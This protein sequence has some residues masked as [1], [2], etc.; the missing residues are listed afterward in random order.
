VDNPEANKRYAEILLRLPAGACTWV[1]V[2]VYRGDNA[3]RV[4]RAHDRCRV[5]LVDP[6]CALPPG[7][8][9]PEDANW[10]RASQAQIE[11][12]YRE[13]V[14]KLAPWRKRV[15]VLRMPSAEAAEQVDTPVD[16]VFIDGHHTYE[17]VRDDIAAWRGKVAPG[18]WLGGHDYDAPRF[19]GV[20]RAVDEA[21]PA[22]V[23]CGE[24]RTW[25]VQI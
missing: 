10:T 14:G 20:K 6:W 25:W 3:R 11:T 19:P 21:F 24:D 1:E 15:T 17:C 4:M 7:E 2:G 12:W 22:G 16:L 23:T 5:I 18:G 9:G 8:A 13:A